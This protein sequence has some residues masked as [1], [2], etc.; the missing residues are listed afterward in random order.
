[1]FLLA[2][3]NGNDFFEL[4]GI[5]LIFVLIIVA[6]YYTTKW[7]GKTNLVNRSAKN[8]TVLETYHNAPGKVIQV[9]KAGKKYIVIGV[10][11]EHMEMLTELSE[12]E[13]EEQ[14][15]SE[16]IE[17]FKFQDVLLK[18]KN[19]TFGRKNKKDEK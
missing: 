5:M 12:D 17:E 14:Q 2:G 8:I 15:V 3:S 11:K 10:T 1:M 9:V 7:I 18:I 16:A 13:Y 19:E 4:L 6:C